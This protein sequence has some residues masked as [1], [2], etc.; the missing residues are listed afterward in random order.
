MK[1]KTKL[2]IIKERNIG[3]INLLKNYLAPNNNKK[4]KWKNR[5]LFLTAIENS[6]KKNKSHPIEKNNE[7]LLS[8][9]SLLKKLKLDTNKKKRKKKEFLEKR[10]KVFKIDD[11]LEIS[12]KNEFFSSSFYYYYFLYA[13][14]LLSILP[15]VLIYLKFIL[16]KWFLKKYKKEI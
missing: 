11:Q 14:N 16:G 15:I 4:K 12:N 5:D 1:K 13:I 2:K 7:D 6:K 8:L 9:F 10:D 3:K